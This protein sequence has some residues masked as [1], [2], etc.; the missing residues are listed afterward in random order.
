MQTDDPGRKEGQRQAAFEVRPLKISITTQTE[1][2]EKQDF[3]VQTSFE[4]ESDS[5]VIQTV[6]EEIAMPNI[7]NSV[8]QTQSKK[9]KLSSSPVT[10]T[11]T[12]GTQ[13]SETEFTIDSSILNSEVYQ[14]YCRNEDPKDAMKQ[15]KELKTCCSFEEPTLPLP[16]ESDLKKGFEEAL[17]ELWKYRERH[18]I[19]HSM[20]HIEPVKV[21]LN[22]GLDFIQHKVLPLYDNG[23]LKC[24]YLDRIM[25]DCF[26]QIRILHPTGF[27]FWYVQNFQSGAGVAKWYRGF[28]NQFAA[29]NCWRFSQR[30][31]FLNV[32]GLTNTVIEQYHY[33]QFLNSIHYKINWLKFAENIY[34]NERE[35]L[36]PAGVRMKQ[37]FFDT[38]Q[39]KTDTTIEIH[40]SLRLISYDN[41]DPD[42]QTFRIYKIYYGKS[43]KEIESRR[44][45]LSKNEKEEMTKEAR[46]AAL[47][48]CFKDRFGFTE[49]SDITVDFFNRPLKPSV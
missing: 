42:N 49:F 22:G 13:C 18:M 3:Q 43:T 37:V 24:L 20:T 40:A 48:E 28:S 15:I 35:A 39:L 23:E 21:F 14:I 9:R 8:G 4:Q 10:T 32:I 44:V 12:T 16:N 6:K 5:V 46:K 11:N 17:Q 7:P 33:E 36:F 45:R 2:S 34:E 1:T 38:V 47:I 41:N 29:S 19:S 25:K 27:E 30:M 26:T 31:A